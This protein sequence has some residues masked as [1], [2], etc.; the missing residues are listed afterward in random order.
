MGDTMKRLWG[1]RH[2]RW[3]WLSW[4]VHQ[5][6]RQCAGIGLGLGCPNES[7]LKVLDAIWRGDA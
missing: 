6:A 1:V 4:R 3:L 5:F 2:I 7:D